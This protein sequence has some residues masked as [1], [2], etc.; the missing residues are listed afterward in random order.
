MLSL[1]GIQTASPYISFRVETVELNGLVIVA[2]GLEGISEEKVARSPVQI[3]GRILRLPPY[4]PVEIL[5]RIVELL[6]KEICDTAAEVQSRIARTQ[7]Q[8]PLQVGQRLG[9]IAET[10][11]RDA[12]VMESVRED[13]IQS[14]RP[15]KIVLGSAK[16]AEVV[17]GYASEEECPVIRRIQL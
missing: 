8:G 15:V 7:L 12:S 6:G 3:G 5:D 14:H 13:R 10:A 1:A 16:V 2:D 11:L 17:L 4:V 9:I